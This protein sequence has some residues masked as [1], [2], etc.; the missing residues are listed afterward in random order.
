M[1]LIPEKKLVEIIG[2]LYVSN[3]LFTEELTKLKVE[4]EKKQEGGN[5]KEKPV[6]PVTDIGKK[7]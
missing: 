2:E 6:A 7:K 4:A 3:I 1:A 5:K